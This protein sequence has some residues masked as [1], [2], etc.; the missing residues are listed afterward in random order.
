MVVGIPFDSN[1]VEALSG[2]ELTGSSGGDG[3]HCA[4][5]LFPGRPLA[6]IQPR[7]CFG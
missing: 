6:G 3:E 4:K 2:E 5:T 7:P 1:A